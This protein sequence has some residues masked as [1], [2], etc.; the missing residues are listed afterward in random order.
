MASAA[1]L[2]DIEI[3]YTER[4][5]RHQPDQAQYRQV[6]DV[7][8][9]LASRAAYHMPCSPPLSRRASELASTTINKPTTDLKS[10]APSGQ[11]KVH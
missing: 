5:E 8:Y 7:E 11:P 4:I 1:L 9:L 3:V 2:N 10:P 6:K